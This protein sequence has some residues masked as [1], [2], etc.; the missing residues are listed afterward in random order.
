V[1]AGLEDSGSKY[2][3]NHEYVSIDRNKVFQFKLPPAVG[4]SQGGRAISRLIEAKPGAGYE[5]SFEA[6]SS[7][8]SLRV[9]VEGFRRMEYDDDA[10]AWVKTLP[11]HANPFKQ[12]VRLKRVYRKQV[13]AGRPRSWTRFSEKFTAPQRYQFDCMFINLYA[14][15]PGEAAYRTVS[16]RQLT[17]R[18]LA[19]FRRENPG[20]RER[21]LR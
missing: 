17:A 6:V 15:L 18:E 4:N 8:P 3:K 2:F 21:R 11:P 1:N 5:I 20:P 7:G 9:F 14:Y 10:T 16:L 19:A 13:P 12:D